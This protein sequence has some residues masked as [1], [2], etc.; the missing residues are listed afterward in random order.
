MPLACKLTS[1]SRIIDAICT[2]LTHMRLDFSRSHL[3][4]PLVAI[5]VDVL[6]DP[7]CHLSVLL[8]VEALSPCR[9]SKLMLACLNSTCLS[10]STIWLR[11]LI[12]WH[13]H[14]S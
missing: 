13:S 9:H 4:L 12:M 14:T 5:F 7:F 3:V 2:R 8:V 1:S 6:V 11:P 10:C